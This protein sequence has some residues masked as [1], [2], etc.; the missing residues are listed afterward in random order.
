[1]VLQKIAMQCWM[2][3]E[4]KYLKK[5]E[6]VCY[7]EP[8]DGLLGSILFIRYTIVKDYRSLLR[9]F[10]GKFLTRLYLSY[11]IRSIKNIK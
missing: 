10:Y 2:N 6:M 1:M 5:K 11:Y 3:R 8:Y 4:Q 7:V 9:I